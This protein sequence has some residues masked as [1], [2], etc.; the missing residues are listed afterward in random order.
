MN[1]LLGAI[2]SLNA[3][4]NELQSNNEAASHPDS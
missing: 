4:I 1:K 3:F 2:G